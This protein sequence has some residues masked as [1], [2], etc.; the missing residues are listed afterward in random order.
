MGNGFFKPNISSFVGSLYKD[1]PSQRD[2]GFTIFYLGINLGAAIAP[3]IC[4]WVAALYGWHYGFMLAG[5]GMLL[6]LAFFQQGLK[7]NVFGEAGKLP[8]EPNYYQKKRWTK[9]RT[10][11]GH[12]EHSQQR[13]F[14]QELSFF[15]SKNII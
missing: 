8:N 6:G 10:M 13:L 5:I 9:S 12:L 7:S 4:A 1:N 11:G 3:L 2:A 14:L 15:T